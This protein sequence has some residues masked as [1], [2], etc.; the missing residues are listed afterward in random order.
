MQDGLQNMELLEERL[1]ALEEEGVDVLTL[2]NE[3]YPANLRAI[4]NAPAILYMRGRVQSCDREAVAIVG[5]RDAMPEA[6]NFAHALAGALVEAGVTVVSGLALGIDGAAHAGALEAGGRTI[7]VLGS[8]IRV[9]FPREH[10]EMALQMVESGAVLSELVPNAQPSGANLMARDRIVSGLSRGVVVVQAAQKSG[11]MDTARR[12]QKQ[13]RPIFAVDWPGNDD[14][15]AG[16]RA[17]LRGEAHALDP[18]AST[19][20]D[21]LLSQLVDPEEQGPELKKQM[22]LF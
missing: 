19:D 16:N 9:I 3:A 6:T 12:A 8:G 14:W 18:E 2:A 13:G 17:L 11:T 10:G 7:G 22:R 21:S 15:T 20:I 4:D 1:Y 5:S